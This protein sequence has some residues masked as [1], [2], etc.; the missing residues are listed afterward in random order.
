TITVTATSPSVTVS[1]TTVSGGA[2]V[3]ATIANG[4][5]NVGDWVGLYV[6]SDPDST[7]VAWN[8][9][10]GSRIRPAAGT[11]SATVP[12]TMPLTAGTY[13][14]RFFSNDSTTRLAT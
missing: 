3:T 4:P 6:T 2:T 14:V 8:Y 10:N 9:L 7:Y 5:G 1:A 12:F 13:N 11:A